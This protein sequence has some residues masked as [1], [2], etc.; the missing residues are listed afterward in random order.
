MTLNEYQKLAG[1]TRQNDQ[2]SIEALANAALGISGEAGEIAEIAKKVLYH[3]HV[4][5]PEKM[6]KELGDELWYISWM[7]ELWG[8]TLEDIARAN[9]Q[10]L[11]ERYPNGFEP[12]R[13]I[14]REE[15]AIHD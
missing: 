13:S 10:K 8:Y 5:E 11:L 4:V 15:E 7:A 9:I 3:R 14:H 12:E 6:L 1:R 2:T